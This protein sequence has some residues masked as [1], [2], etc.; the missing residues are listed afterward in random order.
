M[1]DVVRSEYLRSHCCN[2]LVLLTTV[3]QTYHVTVICS[4]CLN[5]IATP[6][7]EDIS[8]LSEG[9]LPRGHVTNEDMERFVVGMKAA[10]KAAGDGF[11]LMAEAMREIPQ[12][13]WPMPPYDDVMRMREDRWLSRYPWE[14]PQSED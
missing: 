5:I 10:L 3:Q 13:K 7:N 4:G 11:Q 12:L 1:H 9:N 2:T 6:S 8:R 14:S